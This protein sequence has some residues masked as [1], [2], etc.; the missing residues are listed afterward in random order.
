LFLLGH[1]LKALHTDFDSLGSAIDG[2]CD[3]AQI[4]K[5]Y[6]F[7]D[8]VRMGNGVPGGGVLA[9]HFARF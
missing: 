1:G 2:G 4:R 9:A 8:I 6:P 3:G 7:I 5:K